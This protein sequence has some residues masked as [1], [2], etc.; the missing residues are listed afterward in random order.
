MMN[1]KEGKQETSLDEKGM[2]MII[3]EM[4]D[5]ETGIMRGQQYVMWHHDLVIF[6]KSFK[7]HFLPVRFK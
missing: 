5:A 2:T 6:H 7:K 1:M 4:K 3:G